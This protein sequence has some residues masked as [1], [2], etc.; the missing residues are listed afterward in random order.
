MCLE[1]EIRKLRNQ[2]KHEGI[3]NALNHDAIINFAEKMS[4]DEYDRK[5]KHGKY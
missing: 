4:A 1:D 5:R 2:I 3:K